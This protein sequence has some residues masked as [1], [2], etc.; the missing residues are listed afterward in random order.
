MRIIVSCF[1]AG[2]LNMGIEMV[3]GRMLVPI[4]GSSLYQWAGL[5][6][7]ALA[8]YIIGYFLHEKIFCRFQA[9][10]LLIPFFYLLMVRALFAK[11]AITSLHFDL[12]TSSI[13]LSAFI[14]FIP[15]MIWAAFLPYLQ[16]HASVKKPARLLAYSALGN[17]MGVWA[18]SFYLIPSVGTLKSLLFLIFLSG[19]LSILWMRKTQAVLGSVLMVSGFSMILCVIHTNKQAVLFHTDSAYQSITVSKNLT[20][21]IDGNAQFIYHRGEKLNSRGTENYFNYATQFAEKIR[22]RKNPSVLILGLGGGLVAT[23]IKNLYPE[24]E[25][26]VVEIDPKMVEVAKTYF[27]LPSSVNVITDDA[28]SFL[29][30]T[31]KKYDYIFLDTYVNSYVPFHLVTREFTALLAYAL[32]PGGFVAVNLL[33]SQEESGF[34]AK[35]ANTMSE[36]FSTVYRKDL[37]SVI[38]TVLVASNDP[39]SQAM[40][41]FSKEADVLHQVKSADGIFTD[42]LSNSDLLL[43][44]TRKTLA[45]NVSGF[46]LG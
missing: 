10:V 28:R 13:F 33:Q 22:D 38:N 29:S 8:S 24:I 23:Q 15:S 26:S 32:A 44:R 43:Y 25:V 4:L 37:Q 45:V 21:C 3:A 35:F 20:L 36:S 14:I 42:D 16:S 40:L 2:M 46:F 1:I 19:V 34:L 7:T 30:R 11:V 6:G 39:S 12:M 17:L 5:I 27:E 18:I 31:T 41:D 9:L